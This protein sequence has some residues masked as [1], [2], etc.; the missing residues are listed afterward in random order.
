[1]DGMYDTSDDEEFPPCLMPFGK[2]QDW[3]SED[4][5][6]AD[7]VLDV[8]GMEEVFLD[9]FCSEFD[10]APGKRNREVDDTER[11]AKRPKA[12]G[13]E[14]ACAGVV[15]AERAR[16]NSTPSPDYI[17]RLV[18]FGDIRRTKVFV[19]QRLAGTADEQNKA[20]EASK[21]KTN[22]MDATNEGW[23]AR[24]PPP[25]PA[26]KMNK[27]NE[28][29]PSETQFAEDLEK[30]LKLD[31]DKDGKPI[32]DDEFAGVLEKKAREL[33]LKWYTIDKLT[34]KACNHAKTGRVDPE[35][36]EFLVQAPVQSEDDDGVDS[37]DESEGDVF[38]CLWT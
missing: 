22:K 31:Y 34:R 35:L 12:G 1:M 21:A 29:E 16:H 7:S 32:H 30:D 37:E 26:K 3:I 17:A 25:P 33:G 18:K 2:E 38:V 11:S 27:T 6:D 14:L 28:T 15:V 24:L 13:R 5:M 9:D 8:D 19:K 23:I 36:M 4:E 10:I 20:P